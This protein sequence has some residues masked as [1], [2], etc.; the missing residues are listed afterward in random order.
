MVQPLGALTLVAAVPLGA[1]VA[2]RRVGRTEWRGT[3]FTLA[4]LAAI[5]VTASG[6]APDDTLSVSEALL[7]AGATA[8]RKSVV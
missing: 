7:V 3:A 5:L 8:D 6:T 1:W 2:G 4:G